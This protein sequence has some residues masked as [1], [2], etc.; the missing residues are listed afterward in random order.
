VR[1]TPPADVPTHRDRAASG[2]TAAGPAAAAG[3]PRR[4]RR[5]PWL[6]ALGC[7]TV[8]VAV[9]VTWP[10]PVD[11]GA[12]AP[13]GDLFATLHGLGVPAWVDYALLERSA[14][15]VMFVPFG[16]LLTAMDRRRWWWGVLLPAAV[17]GAAELAQHL[18]LPDRFATWGD[19]ASNSAG[20]A[21]GVAVTLAVMAARRPGG[22]APRRRR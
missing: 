18:L 14:N 11:S 20:A 1:H 3:R 22:R 10:T 17:S 16:V 13:L 8:L 12:R 15:V 2:R 5:L 21:L 19:V 4:R 9:V 7:Y 6:V